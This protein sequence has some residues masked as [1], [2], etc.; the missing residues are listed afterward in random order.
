M[1]DE[2]VVNVV[3]Q[4]DGIH[5]G[6]TE[7]VNVLA[8][9]N[10]VGDVV[11]GRLFRLLVCIGGLI[12]F[13]FS[14]SGVLSFVLG[15][16]GISLCCFLLLYKILDGQI[17]AVEILVQDGVCHLFAEFAVLDSAKFDERA[18]IIPVFFIILAVGLAHAGELVC[19]LLCDVVGD[20]LYKAVV[21]QSASGYVQ[22]QI[23]A[24]DDTL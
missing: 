6:L 18:D 22:R 10:L 12:L 17:F 23:R 21:L 2:S 8:L 4:D 19:D 9:L 11:D 15:F 1:G 5:A 13:L 14:G 20:L 3:L 16:G 7:H 24:V